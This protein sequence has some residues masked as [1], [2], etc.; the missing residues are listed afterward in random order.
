MGVPKGIKYSQLHKER[1]GLAKLGEKNPNWAGYDTKIEYTALHAWVRKR[2][3]KPDTCPDCKTR[4]PYDLANITG[5]YNRDLE[6]WKYLCRSCHMLS[7]G[8][9][10]NLAQSLPPEVRSEIARTREAI[11]YE[12]KLSAL[13]KTIK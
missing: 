13:R 2:F 7:D 3:P 1:I 9:M 6:N 12:K 10:K 5:T 4:P 11:R 8:R